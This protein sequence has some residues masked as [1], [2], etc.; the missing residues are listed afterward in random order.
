MSAF[1][2]TDTIKLM[3]GDKVLQSWNPNPEAEDQGGRIQLQSHNNHPGNP[4]YHVRPEDRDAVAEGRVSLCKAFDLASDACLNS[5]LD[6][7][8]GAIVPPG[9]NADDAFDESFKSRFPIVIEPGTYFINRPLMKFPGVDI[10]GGNTMANATIRVS[11]AHQAHAE[12][13]GGHIAGEKIDGVGLFQ[14]GRILFAGH[15]I[16]AHSHGV[17][18]VRFTSYNGSRIAAFA[19]AGHQ[20]NPRYSH[21]GALGS[22]EDAGFGFASVKQERTNLVRENLVGGRVT[23][24][25]EEP[26]SFDLWLKDYQFERFG[27]GVLV[28]GALAPKIEGSIWY[29]NNSL[30]LS[31][32][33]HAATR[34][35][36]GDRFLDKPKLGTTKCAIYVAG[37]NN[38][39]QDNIQYAE[40]A[41]VLMKG[42]GNTIRARNAYKYGVY[43]C[44]AGVYAPG[45]YNHKKTGDFVPSKRNDGDLEYVNGTFGRWKTGDS[46]WGGSLEAY[47][48]FYDREN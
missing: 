7:A 28:R 12:A 3:V 1:K 35:F 40:D 10:E 26:N 45:K 25:E 34:N 33:Y 37:N 19:L 20:T 4:L 21:I 32:C 6:Q 47:K 15:E 46:S 17:S 18:G 27:I 8:S 13:Y 11:K 14:V 36:I 9:A 43:K 39:I 23:L 22:H 48:R 38:Y 31:A 2:D 44:A 16:R 29:C 42:Y 5:A 24:L 30:V 41:G